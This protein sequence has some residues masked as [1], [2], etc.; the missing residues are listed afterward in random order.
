[1]PSSDALAACELHEYWCSEGHFY[2]RVQ[3][4]VIINFH[5]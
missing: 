1:M 2:L 5:I 4:N 3:I